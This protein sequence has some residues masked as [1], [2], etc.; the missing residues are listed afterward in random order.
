[1]KS[2]R[3][4]VLVSGLTSEGD[5]LPNG[6]RVVRYVP[7]GK[8][9]RDPEDDDSYLHPDPNAFKARDGEEELSVTWCEY[10]EGTP[11]QV[12]RCAVEAIRKSR[13]AA[14]KACFCVASAAEIIEAIQQFGGK[15]RAVYLPEHDNA[16]HSGIVGIDPENARLLQTLAYDVWGEFYTKHAADALPLGPCNAVQNVA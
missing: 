1:M 10:F 8:M 12:L 4:S 2:Y 9:V 3:L 5:D 15:G 16:A 14:P 13:V 6:S 11:E 7:Y